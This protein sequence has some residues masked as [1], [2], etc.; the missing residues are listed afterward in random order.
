MTE[1]K[2]R[3]LLFSKLTECIVNNDGIIFGGYVRDTLLHHEGAMQY[4]R[5]TNTDALY[6]DSSYHT[7][8]FSQRTTY[9]N[10][11]DVFVSSSQIWKK[12]VEKF[13]SYLKTPCTV[14]ST[15]RISGYNQHPNF[16]LYFTVHRHIFD[17]VYDLS[18]QNRGKHLLVT[19]DVVLPN[20]PQIS[21]DFFKSRCMYDCSCNLF[22]LD[23]NGLQHAIVAGDM[24]TKALK[25]SKL[26]EMTVNKVC[27]IPKPHE[28]FVSPP[29]DLEVRSLMMSNKKSYS[30]SKDFYTLNKN[31]VKYKYRV[32]LIKRILKL[33]RL[34][35][36][37]LNSPFEMHLFVGSDS[38]KEICNHELECFISKEEFKIG[39]RI[40]R[41]R[42]GSKSFMNESSLVN[43]INNP[44]PL[45]VKM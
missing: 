17:Y 12:I 1:A 8:S 10:D 43:C 16:T 39:S 23:K 31:E 7:E 6:H 29:E 30:E 11:I 37:I 5:V 28:S 32:K 21:F 9:P 19:M 22:Y 25:I 24:I 14:K 3:H 34:G 45:L 18:L 33:H 35:W 4:Y 36:T 40:Y 38:C 44:T 13:T 26:A 20:N 2:E 41:V 42:D 27:F 15:K